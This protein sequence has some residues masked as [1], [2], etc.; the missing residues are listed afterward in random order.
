LLLEFV[1][2]SLDASANATNKSPNVKSCSSLAGFILQMC[3]I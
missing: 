3:C 2:F 1:E